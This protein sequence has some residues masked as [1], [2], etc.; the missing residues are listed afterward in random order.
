MSTDTMR[1]CKWRYIFLALLIVTLQVLLVIR[2]WNGTNMKSRLT[3]NTTNSRIN[4][5]S[6]TTK[7]NISN[8]KPRLNVIILTRMRSGSTFTGNMFNFHPDVFYL[9]EPLNELRI[10]TYG[11]RDLGERPSLDEKANEAYGIDFSNLLQDIFTCNF[12]RNTTLKLIFTNWLRKSKRGTLAWKSKTT[13]ISNESMA[14]LCKSRKITVIKIMQTRLPREIGIRELQRVCT[15]EPTRFECLIIHLVRD[16]RAVTT[17]AIESRFFLPSGPKKNLIT[18]KN[19]T[20]EGKEII[21]NNARIICSLVEENLNYVNEEWSNWFKDRYILVRYEDM[22]GDLLTAVHRMYNFTGLPMVD[23]VKKWIIEGKSSG[24]I[25]RNQSE[26]VISK[27]DVKKRDHWRFGIGFALAAEFE[28]VCWP[29]MYIMGYISI[30]GSERLLHDTKYRLWT[31][32][33]PFSF[34]GPRIAK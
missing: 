26:F 12:N 18:L 21:K 15:S 19:P 9:F 22:P 14:E 11:D 3:I 16:P 30:N 20:S 29:L 25:K 17:S 13:T 32:K 7:V 6:N 28:E 27:N 33:M 10:V 2:P 23:Y 4:A 1:R 5:E 8:N 24:G 34:G 31:E